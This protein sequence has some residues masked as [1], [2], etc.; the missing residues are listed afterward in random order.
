MSN[1]FFKRKRQ[2]EYH[3]ECGGFIANFYFKEGSVVDSYLE[4]RSELGAWSMK[5]D[6]RYEV[7]GY[8]FAAAE[9]GLTEQI[10]GY[11][12]TMYIAS[13][14]MTKDQGLVNDLQKSITKYMKRIEKQAETEAKNVSEEQIAGD[15]ALMNEAIERGKLQ[16]DK[17]AERK[18]AKESQEEIKKVLEEDA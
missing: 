16:G 11:C 12:V 8:L 7:F 14:Q 5:I 1:K 9:K 2:P 15:E 18:A 4:I 13:T 3:I 17:K 10:H 6:A